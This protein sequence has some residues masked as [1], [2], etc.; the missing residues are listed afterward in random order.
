MDTHR[1]NLIIGTYSIS[2]IAGKV[3]IMS[4]EYCSSPD[5]FAYPLGILEGLAPVYPFVHSFGTHAGTSWYTRKA[6]TG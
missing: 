3:N 6:L 2:S 5:G 1:G 4:I